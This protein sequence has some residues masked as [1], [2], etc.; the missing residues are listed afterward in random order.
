MS[1]DDES[2]F[3]NRLAVLVDRNHRIISKVFYAG[4]AVGA[5]AVFRSV[6]GVRK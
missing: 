1:D 4:A 5:F 6:R 3:L 2:S